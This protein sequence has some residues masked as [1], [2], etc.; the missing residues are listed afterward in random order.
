MIGILN[1]QQIEEVLHDQLVGRIGCHLNGKTFIV[2]I[3]YAYDD[4]YIYVYS[5][6]GRK[7]EMMRQ[8][9]EVCFEVDE[10]YDMSNWKSVVAWGAFEEL[11][12]SHERQKA[13]K[14]LSNRSL[15]LLPAETN[16]PSQRPLFEHDNINDIEGIFY[17]IKL[18]EKN[19]R[20]KNS[21][22]ATNPDSL[23]DD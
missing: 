5:L 23:N 17:R 13:L 21:L 10:I 19:G 11:K 14:I 9:N 4:P 15:P 1:Y 7:V 6:Q 20:F 22:P 18:T 8:N 2:P 16:G 3:N 12:G